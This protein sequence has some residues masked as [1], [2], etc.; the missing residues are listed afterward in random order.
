MRIVFAFMAF[1]CLGNPAAFA[2]GPP[3]GAPAGPIERVHGPLVHADRSITFTLE[4]PEAH[5]VLVA[6]GDGLGHGPFPMSKDSRGRWTVTT[7]PA[8]VGFH[9]YWFLLD[10]V[11]VDDPGSHTYFGYDKEVSGLEVPDDQGDY[12]AIKDVPQG[13]L[14]AYWYRSSVT[15]AWRRVLVYTP[16]GYDDEHGTRYPVLYLQHGAGEDETGWSRQGR[17]EHILDNLLAARQAK[18]MIVVMDCGYAAHPGQ[19]LPV[20]T[21]ATTKEQGEQAFRTF[22]DV[23]LRDLIPMID[24]RYRTLADRDHRAFAGLSMGAMQALFIALRHADKFAYIG[25]FSGPFIPNLNVGPQGF[26]PKTSYGGA[27]ADPAAFNKRFRLLWMG[28]GTDEAQFRPAISAAA[29]A[30]RSSGVHLVYFESQGTAHEWQTWR[31]D[32]RDFLP[33]LF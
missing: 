2:A 19:P 32:L 4:A 5:S 23:M 20:F 25:D 17:A 33:R 15:G 31:R 3:D 11:A 9:Y 26:D 24:T 27:F 1:A 22:E 29:Q 14:R 13:E 12:Y 18:P 8:T 28:V 16:A 10:G 30:L 7:P 21:P 6:G